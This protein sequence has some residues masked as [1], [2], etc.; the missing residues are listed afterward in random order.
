M[1]G[2]DPLI[3]NNLITANTAGCGGG[4]Y[5]AVPSG[6][7]GP[8]LINNT[9]SGNF[10]AGVWASGFDAQAQLINNIIVAPSFDVGVFCDTTR[11]PNPPVF[12]SNDVFGLS[13]FPSS[14]SGCGNPTGVNGNISVDPH[15]VDPAN[16]DFHVRPGSA[17]IDAGTSEL[18]PATD[19][20]GT[21]RPIDG[22]GDG[23]A[24]FDMGS[25]ESPAG[26]PPAELTAIKT[27]SSGGTVGFGTR[28]TW[29][30][31]V[32]NSGPGAAAFGSGQV[33]LRDELPNG[34]ITYGTA[35]VASVG[36]VSGAI[37]CVINNS[38]LICGANGNVTI[39]APG[40]LV[41][42]LTANASIPGTFTNP[43]FGGVCAA[44]PDGWIAETNKGNNTCSD[45]V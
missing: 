10:G 29:S 8:F 36:N 44:D 23:T 43:R 20:N 39:G 12:K 15:F 4:V 40:S 32:A 35:S 2:S 1:N 37:S 41:V 25:Y 38:T 30:I 42:E 45:A 16:G 27:N 21:S 13:P 17:T 9:V 3:V 28:W 31:T 18:A 14:Y 33:I 34:G 22:N 6:G 5:W 7:R 26:G 19:L 24:A 11:D